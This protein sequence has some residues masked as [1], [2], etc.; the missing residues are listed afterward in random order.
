MIDPIL[1][2]DDKNSDGY[3]DYAEFVQAQANVAS[4]GTPQPAPAV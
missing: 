1:Q 3:I 2:N 4:K